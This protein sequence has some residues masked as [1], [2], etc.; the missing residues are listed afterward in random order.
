[1][2]NITQIRNQRLKYNLHVTCLL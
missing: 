1:M 2:S